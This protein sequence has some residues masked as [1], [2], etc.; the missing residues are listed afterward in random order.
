M[1][2]IFIAVMVL[3]LACN[4][5]RHLQ[6]PYNAPSPQN[7][8]ITGKLFTSLYQQQ[9][10]EYRALCFQAYNIA[11]VRVD[12][13]L[14]SP[15]Q[16]PKAIVT[17][18]DETLLD[19]SAY[20][21]HQTLQNKDYE[22]PSWYDWT[23]RSAADTVP[24][25]LSFLQYAASKGIEVFYVTN[26]EERERAGTLLNLQKFH[27]PNADN[28]HLLV[29]QTTSSK[30]ARRQE[31]ASTHEIILLLGDNLA[32]F[33][34]LFDRKT[35]DERLKNTNLTAEEFGKKFIILPNP[36]YGDWESSMYKYNYTLTNPQKDSLIKTYPKSY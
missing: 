28:A 14:K 15:A 12:E 7:I 18:I 31:V 3:M 33:S 24:G 11:H 13:S 26:R 35:T 8:A 22:A 34:Y 19:N 6:N 36:V 25:G 16:K 29:K 2:K 4:T 9:A 21:L 23:S 5:S 10:A 1:K 17:D 32:D 27:F 20:E 30:E